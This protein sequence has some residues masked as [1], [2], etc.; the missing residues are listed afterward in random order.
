MTEY[1]I[2]SVLVFVT[3]KQELCCEIFYVVCFHWSSSF[4]F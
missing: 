4:L 1:N 2:I 3:Y